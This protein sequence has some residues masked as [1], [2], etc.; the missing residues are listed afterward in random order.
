MFEV[1]SAPGLAAGLA[2]IHKYLPDLI[3]VDLNLPDSSGYETF[4]RVRERAAGNPIIVLTGLDDDRLAIRAVEDGAHD[5]LVKSAIQPKLIARCISMAFGRQGRKVSPKAEAPPVPAAVLS[6]IGSKGGV[7]T[8]TTAVNIAALLAQSGFET[9]VIELQPGRP[10][11]LPMYSPSDPT[12]GLNSLLKRPADA[13]TPVALQACV[14]KA[15]AGLYLLCPTASSETWRAIGAEH[16]HA[17]IAAA[18]RVCR[19]I[20]LDLPARIDEGIAAALQLSD[21]LALIVDR[22]AASVHCGAA[23][24]EQLRLARS[25]SKEVHLVVVDRTVLEVPLPLEDIKKQFKMH[26]LAFI[27]AAGAAIALSQAAR[28]PLVLLSPDDPFATAHFDLAR[29][30]LSPATV[31]PS[32]TVVPSA[33]ARSLRAACH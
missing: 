27:P 31:L 26:P 21:S 22:E 1:K 20:V 18:R 25:R 17:I 10:G 14:V 12:Q 19:F 2:A 32:K 16:V 5:Y 15:L 3:L 6:F 23:F 29:H 13:I 8:S 28:T 24:L 33:A 4:L 30:L 7:G 11:T 9:M